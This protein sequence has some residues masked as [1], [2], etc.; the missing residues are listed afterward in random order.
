M[1]KLENMVPK[2]LHIIGT[3]TFYVFAF[4]YCEKKYRTKKNT[5]KQTLKNRG[6]C[7][8]FGFFFAKKKPVNT[9]PLMNVTRKYESTVR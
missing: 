6:L 4:F 2:R 3:N 9:V 8:H 5:E 1:N 7:R